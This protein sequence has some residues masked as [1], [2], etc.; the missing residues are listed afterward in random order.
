MSIQ[1][2]SSVNNVNFKVNDVDSK[3]TNVQQPQSNIKDGKKKLALA[4]AALGAVAAAGVAIYKGKG[5]KLS[6]IAYDKGVAFSQN[7]EKFTGKIKDKLANGDKIVMEYVDGVLQKSTRSGQVNFEKMYETVNGEKIVKKTVD[8]VVTE[9]NLT[10]VQQEVKSA[11]DKLKN[12]INQENP[13]NVAE[14]PV[15]KLVEETVA[16]ANKV[17]DETVETVSESAKVTTK[18]TDETTK[19]VASKAEEPTKKVAEQVTKKLSGNADERLAALK[20]SE[21]GSEALE[22]L[23]PEDLEAFKKLNPEILEQIGDYRLSRYLDGDV[24]EITTTLNNISPETL[25][26]LNEVGID[27]DTLVGG[28][29]MTGKKPTPESILELAKKEADYWGVEFNPAKIEKTME[30]F[31][32]LARLIKFFKS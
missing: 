17:V 14:Q 29:S 3:D 21:F 18:T 19:K 20:N 5:T 9:T 23:T 25:K 15:A 32:N 28:L 16:D 27:M 2:A 31:A 7:G 13:K 26:A 22:K 24:Q 30:A 4:L 6:D 1:N 12:I 8:D 10:K 11:Q